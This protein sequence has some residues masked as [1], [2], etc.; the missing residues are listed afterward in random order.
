MNNCQDRLE[1]H[2]YDRKVPK[3]ID[4]NDK[5]ESYY[6]SKEEIN[7]L[8]EKDNKIIINETGK[9]H[10]KKIT[11]VTTYLINDIDIELLLFGLTDEVVHIE[12]KRV[13]EETNVANKKGEK[14][15]DEPEELRKKS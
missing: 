14:E 12:M 5:L 8:I 15:K 1:Y 7:L 11:G 9:L 2:F 6:D 3:S 13:S 4:I 10:K